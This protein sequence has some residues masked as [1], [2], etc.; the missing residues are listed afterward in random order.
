MDKLLLG[1]N[2]KPVVGYRKLIGSKCICSA[3]YTCSVQM[4]YENIKSNPSC[5][6][7][8]VM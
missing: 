1:C 5:L 8:A 2:V 3:F 6:H 4:T 7:F